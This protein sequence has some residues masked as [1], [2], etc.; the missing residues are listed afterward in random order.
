MVDGASGQELLVAAMKRKKARSP[1]LPTVKQIIMANS[2]F[3]QAVNL[4]QLRHMGQLS[5]SQ[6]VSNCEKRAIGSGG[7]YG[8]RS[9]LDGAKVKLMDSMILAAWACTEYKG[10]KKQKVSC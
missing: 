3:S 5:L 4:K 6:M 1:L 7:G 8:F 10:P 9:I 2:A